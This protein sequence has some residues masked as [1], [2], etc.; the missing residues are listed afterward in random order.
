MTF[1]DIA[2][3]TRAGPAKAL[4]ISKTK[5]HLGV[6]ADADVSDLQLQP[7]DSGQH[8]GH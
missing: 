8:T 5:G 7:E 1:N 6:G 4:G 2:T 3:M